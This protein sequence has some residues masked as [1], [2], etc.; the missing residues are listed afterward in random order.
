MCLRA[1]AASKPAS[2][3]TSAPVVPVAAARISSWGTSRKR[4]VTPRSRHS[5]RSSIAE[6][7]DAPSSAMSVMSFQ[8]TSPMSSTVRTGP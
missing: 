1:F 7:R 2:P 4:G 8:G 6:L 3:I 5:R